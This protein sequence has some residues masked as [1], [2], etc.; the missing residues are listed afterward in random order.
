[1]DTIWYDLPQFKIPYQISLDNRVKRLAYVIERE[2]GV[3][4]QLPEIELKVHSTSDG[5]LYVNLND[6]CEHFKYYPLHR[7]VASI[8]LK[9][10]DPSRYTE[11]NHIDGNKHNNK[12]ENLEWVDHHSNMLH[13]FNS[14]LV[15][16]CMPVKCLTNGQVY[17]SRTNAAHQLGINPSDVTDSINFKISKK[18]FIFVDYPPSEE[19]DESEYVIKAFENEKIHKRNMRNSICKKIYAI[20]DNDLLEFDSIVEAQAYFQ[21]FGSGI[22]QALKSGEPKFGVSFVYADEVRDLQSFSEISEYIESKYANHHKVHYWVKCLDND[23]IYPSCEYTA[24]ELSISIESVVTSI[25]EGRSIN[26]YKQHRK[27]QFVRASYEDIKN[28]QKASR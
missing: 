11:I 3:K 7:L 12:P 22:Q 18:G 14:G 4:T 17:R 5:Y 15:G 24:R 20:F 26:S 25:K 9:N 28:H 6:G 2:D 10:S 27:F 23:Q 19:F 21:N 8:F 1:M 13:A 16:N